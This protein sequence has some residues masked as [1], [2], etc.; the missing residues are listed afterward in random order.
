MINNG[1][2]TEVEAMQD[3]Y[4][5]AREKAEA[6]TGLLEPSS[7]FNYLLATT[8]LCII[9]LKNN[10]KRQYSHWNHQLASILSQIKKEKESLNS[11]IN[12][13]NYKLVNIF[14]ITEINDGK[15]ANLNQIKQDLD[16]LKMQYQAVMDYYDPD[17]NEKY[18]QLESARFL[19]EASKKNTSSDGKIIN[20]SL[21]LLSN[22][23]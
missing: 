18:S 4:K 22:I 10:D 11:T 3:A 9:Q 8:A 16:D 14:L 12:L 21:Q 13:L 7:A 5:V 15:Y 17:D 2:I 1:G 19:Y 20:Q 23:D 6:V